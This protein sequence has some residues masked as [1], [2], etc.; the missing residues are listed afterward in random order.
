MGSTFQLALLGN[1]STDVSI[2]GIQNGSNSITAY[3]FT[4]C[5]AAS[6]RQ[7]RKSPAGKGICTGFVGK[8]ALVTT[9]QTNVNVLRMGSHLVRR[10]ARA[11]GLEV[12]P[13]AR[14][15]RAQP[16]AA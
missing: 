6:T 2:E 5:A 11:K 15:T 8:L 12:L 10:P 14:L 3:R 9:V 16:H 13:V 7:R 1:V 4:R